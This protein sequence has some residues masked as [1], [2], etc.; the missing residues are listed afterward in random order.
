[1][2]PYSYLMSPNGSGSGHY[3]EL[4]ETKFLELIRLLLLQVEVDEDW[5]LASYRDVEDAVRSGALK[6]A[7]AHYIRAGYFE[8]R[9]PRPF[10]VDEAWYLEEYPDVADAIQSGAFSS[11]SVH[12]ERDGFREGRLPYADWSL[13][14]DTLHT[15]FA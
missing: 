3:V 14:G 1:M 5:Y 8:N 11:A 6:S 7:R 2:R 9:I 12:F 13:L 10:K 15:E 4:L